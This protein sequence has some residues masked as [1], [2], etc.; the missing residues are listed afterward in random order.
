[1]AKRNEDKSFASTGRR[2]FLMAASLAGAV[3]TPGRAMAAPGTTTHPHGDGTTYIID[4]TSA[5][6]ETESGKVVGYIRNDI[7]IFKGIP[8]AEIHSPEGRWMRGS[9]TRPW[10]GNRPSRAVGPVC[11]PGR[12]PELD[13]NLDEVRFRGSGAYVTRPGEDCLRINIWTPGLDNKKR[14]VM[15]WC[16]GGGFTGGSSLSSIQYEFANLAQHGDVVIVSVNHRLSCLGFLD[17]TAYGERFAESAN[18]GMLDLVDALTW[19]RRNIPNFGGDPEKLTIFGHSGGGAKVAALMAM[20]E[21]KGLFNRA[22]I[23]SPGPLPFSTPA[24]S[25]V[26]TATFLKLV[27]I[28]P[29]NLDAL[30]KLPVEKL[31]AAAGIITGA[32]NIAR[33]KFTAMNTPANKNMWKPLVDGRTVLFES[34]QPNAPSNVP[35][36]LG[37]ALHEAFTAVGHPEYDEMNEQQ[38]REVLRDYLGPI[39]DQVYNVY[40][41]TFP[42]ANPFEVSAAARATEHMRQY[43]VKLAQ[44]R[45]A[46]NAAPTY[47]YWFRWRA[48]ILGGRPKSHHELEVP[49][50]FLH[51][52]DTPE[53]TG[54]TTEARA[55]GVTLADTWLQFARTGDPNNKALPRWTPVAPKSVTAM[56]FDNHCRIDQGSDAVAIDLI[57]KSQ[58]SNS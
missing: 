57:W 35:V 58:H 39:S 2:Q 30:Y 42:N 4:D 22:I 8:Y 3:L 37:T 28:S 13:A 31:T 24:E 33:Y 19:V 47:L 29:S 36:M 38:A 1:M 40:K 21:A 50:A 34:A 54:A 56:T 26:R 15:F 41:G 10:A 32:A 14:N 43:C 25:E 44:N 46:F 52:D 55:L 51:S 11:H 23:Q 9:K 12:G 7:R 5:V 53:I 27:D 18:L 49:L 6:G 17:L 20:P 16:H 48:K 45:A